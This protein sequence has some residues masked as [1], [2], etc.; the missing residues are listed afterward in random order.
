VLAG[1]G[2]VQGSASKLLLVTSA[3]AE[4]QARGTGLAPRLRSL[5][6]PARTH[7]CAEPDHTYDDQEEDERH[8]EKKR[9]AQFRHHGHPPPL[10]LIRIV[11]QDIYCN[12]QE[13]SENPILF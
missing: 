4:V 7:D 10:L 9:G 6:P 12:R 8:H 11:H 13:R 1:L 5:T 3:I 2:F